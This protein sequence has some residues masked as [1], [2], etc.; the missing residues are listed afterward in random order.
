MR[1]FLLIFMILLVVAGTGIAFSQ[2]QGT[3]QGQTLGTASQPDTSPM[4][5]QMRHA[6]APAGPL[7]IT[8]AGKSAEWTPETLAPLPDMTITV[9]NEHA[10][11]NQTYSGVPLTDLLARLGLP[12][13]PRGKDFRLYVVAEGS[14]GYA[15]VYSLGEITPDLPTGRCWWP[16]AEMEKISGMRDSFSLLP[17]G[18]DALP[19]GSATWSRSA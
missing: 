10:K 12:I 19:A 4:Q 6:S 15:V 16:T 8:F 5:E 1:R 3:N 11:A 13:K 17:Q 14:D 7:K 18:K 9:Y 2:N